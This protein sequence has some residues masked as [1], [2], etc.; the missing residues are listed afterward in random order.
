MVVTVCDLSRLHPRRFHDPRLASNGS[1]IQPVIEVVS[2]EAQ[3]P[4]SPDM[5]R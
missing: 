2:V 3:S 5:G 1:I 4:T